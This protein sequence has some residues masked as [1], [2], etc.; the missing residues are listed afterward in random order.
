MESFIW[1]KQTIDYT[2]E[3]ILSQELFTAVKK[4]AGWTEI[5]RNDAK[6][7]FSISAHNKETNGLF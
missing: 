4:T 7:V 3:R 5:L 6:D 1:S 2:L